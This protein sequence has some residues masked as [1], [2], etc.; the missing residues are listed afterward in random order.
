MNNLISKHLNPNLLNIPIEQVD[1]VCA[2]T[3]QHIS[4]GVPL[5]KLIKKT[6]TDQELIR[7]PSDYASV[8]IALMM[9]RVISGQKGL[10]SL[11][12]YSFYATEKELK[13]LKRDEILSLLLEIP[14][15]P[16][17][18]A[19][20]FSHKKHI[21]YRCRI[22]FDRT[23]FIITTDKGNVNFDKLIAA[24]IVLILQRWYK[25]LPG[26]ETSKLQPTYFTKK[27]ISGEVI[28]KTSKIKEYGIKYYFK[29]NQ[30]LDKYRKTLL[31][32]LLVYI[33][34]KKS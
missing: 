14:K 22:N 13:L 16:F 9:E 3:G 2:F 29:E 34:N 5:K 18:I 7:Y 31:F 27:E 26:Q 12:N 1:T 4:E 25:I 11:R 6:F 33:L 21:A 28:P 17:Q 20:T 32:E 8:D 15:A 30:F 10:T 19:I 24:D 23:K